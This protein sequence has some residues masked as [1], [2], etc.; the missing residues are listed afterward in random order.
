MQGSIRLK[1]AFYCVLLLVGTALCGV[2]L[3]SCGGAPTPFIVQGPGVS[4]N[5]APTLTIEAPN[6][7]TTASRGDFIPIRWTDA[8]GDSNAKIS[9]SL[10]NTVTNEIILLIQGIDENDTI[11]P[12]QFTAGTSLIPVGTYNLLGVIDD[13]V[14]APVESFAQTTAETVV[15][16]LV[17][18]IVPPGQGPPT[19]PP[20]VTVTQPAFNLSVAQDDVLNVTVQPNALDPAQANPFDE[21]SEV[22]L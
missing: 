9:F 15:Q 10:V 13:G 18:T 21:D 16:R 17:I 7:N 12:D 19:V 14:N 20:V 11:G 6:Q 4:G 22:T 2:G 3:S 1:S 8:D 5:E